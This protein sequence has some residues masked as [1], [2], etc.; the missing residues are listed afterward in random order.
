ME[1]FSAEDVYE[2][3]K[4]IPYGKV[5]TYGEI[6]TL[7]GFP[8]HSRHVGVAM[9][10]AWLLGYPCHR[11]IFADGRLVPG[12]KEQRD[13]LMA[14]GVVIKPN[15]KVDMEKSAWQPLEDERL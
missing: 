4:H 3:M 6:A 11:V 8:N 12:W 13:L 7:V 15:G 9:H 1:K 14:E 10:K 2:V 5:V